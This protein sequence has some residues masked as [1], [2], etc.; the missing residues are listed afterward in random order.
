MMFGSQR[1]SQPHLV[2]DSTRFLLPFSS[3]I[4][5]EFHLLTICALNTL[6]DL[7]GNWQASCLKTTGLTTCFSTYFTD[8]FVIHNC[9]FDVFLLNVH[10]YFIRS[11]KFTAAKSWGDHDQTSIYQR[12]KNYYEPRLLS[13][14]LHETGFFRNKR[15]HMAGWKPVCA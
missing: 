8:Y 3:P 9:L 10:I 7:L 5:H 6:L 2:H 1:S 15:N 11:K 14:L 4:F 13:K 12:K